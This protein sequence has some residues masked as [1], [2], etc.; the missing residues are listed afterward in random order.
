[1]SSHEHPY[2][3]VSSLFIFFLF[4]FV[5]QCEIRAALAGATTMQ[6]N[7]IYEI[8]SPI[9]PLLF[10]YAANKCERERVCRENVMSGITSHT[11]FGNPLAWTR[12]IAS[13]TINKGGPWN[14]LLLW[15]W[16]W[17][18]LWLLWLFASVCL[19]PNPSPLSNNLINRQTTMA[20]LLGAFLRTKRNEI[21]CPNDIACRHFLL[22]VSWVLAIE[23]R[24]CQRITFPGQ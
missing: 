20:A 12:F 6:N 1:M 8:F 23:P 3:M 19:T 13:L 11:Q 5:E 18:P 15:L 22:C 14:G 21:V 2:W 10:V 24:S 16:I 9:T 7:S 17:P 4:G